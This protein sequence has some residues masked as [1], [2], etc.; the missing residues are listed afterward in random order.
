V[1]DG[2]VEKFRETFAAPLSANMQEARETLFGD[3]FD[4]VAM[5]L[6]MV[7]FDAEAT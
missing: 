2:I 1:D 4:R 3:G 5:N 7:G 6:N